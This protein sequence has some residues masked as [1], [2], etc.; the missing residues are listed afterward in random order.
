MLTILPFPSE[1]AGLVRR[2]WRVGLR[3]I[4]A[5]FWSADAALKWKLIFDGVDYATIIG[6]GSAGQP[7]WLS[8]WIN[9]WSGVAKG[10]PGFAYVIAAIETVI[11]LFLLTGF[12]TNWVSFGGMVFAFLTWSTAEAFGG[13]FV[14]GATDIGTMPLYIAMFAGLIVVQAGRDKGLDA[15]LSRRYKRLPFV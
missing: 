7:S 10:T 11:A 13:I 15:I 14:Q 3:L 2:N 5:L 6:A 12:L 4:F 8:S 1:G 9:Y